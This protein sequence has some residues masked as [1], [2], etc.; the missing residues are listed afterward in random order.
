MHLNPT[1]ND[2]HP[3]FY[4]RYYHFSKNEPSCCLQLNPEAGGIPLTKS[5]HIVK[6][7]NEF[8]FVHKLLSDVVDHYT[9]NPQEVP[10]KWI[11]LK[12]LIHNLKA[13]NKKVDSYN[14][15]IDS[16]F[17]L[18]LINKILNFIS[19]SLKYKHLSVEALERSIASL[20]NPFEQDQTILGR[21]LYRHHKDFISH[22]VP[23]NRVQTL[24]ERGT[25]LS[26]EA[27]LRLREEHLGRLQGPLY[28]KA[29]TLEGQE[30]T[31]LFEK[32][33]KYCE[34][35]LDRNGYPVLRHKNTTKRAMIDTRIDEVARSLRISSVSVR[36]GLDEIVKYSPSVW[37]TPNFDS[38]L[39]SIFQRC[40]AKSE[41]KNNLEEK[42][43]YLAEC[44][45]KIT[46]LRNDANTGILRINQIGLKD[47]I[48]VIYDSVNWEAEA[49]IMLRGD[50]SMILNRELSEDSTQLDTDQL[51]PV[52]ANHGMDVAWPLADE[53]TIL[54]GPRQ[55]LQPYKD[56]YPNIVFFDEIT[57][58][59]KSHL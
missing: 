21:W 1:F 9:N 41:M 51:P 48:H 25:L 7:K 22:T 15:K 43:R 14:A 27:N 45:R 37:R 30:K 56:R 38:I 2:L 42:N 50:A 19:Y 33:K 47:V 49:L 34:I 44:K 35:D 18:R 39:S 24:F 52:W 36:I 54:L 31:S 28:T 4:A 29:I 16:S 57:P 26:D 46:L 17:L 20:L 58:E 10:K 32:W 11:S 3:S 23:S 8:A 53:N 12:K 55:L 40:V 6:K 59:Q 5:I 13:W